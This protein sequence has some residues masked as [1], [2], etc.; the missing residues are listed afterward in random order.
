MTAKGSI[1]KMHVTLDEVEAAI[2]RAKLMTGEVG[3]L[4]VNDPEQGLDDYRL[5]LNDSTTTIEIGAAEYPGPEW[6]A[7]YKEAAQRGDS[8]RAR[9]LLRRGAAALREEE[10]PRA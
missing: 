8:E 7:A 3:I 5:D 10:P 9:D 1:D 6:Y 2:A 4:F